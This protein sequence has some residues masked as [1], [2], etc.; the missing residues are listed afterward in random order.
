MRKPDAT[1]FIVDDDSSVRSGTARLVKSIGMRAETFSSAEEFL[2]YGP[3]ETPSCL[4]LDLRMPGLSGMDLQEE[5]RRRDMHVPI[6]FISGYGD[7]P[8][9]VQAMKSGAQDFLTKPFDEEELVSA[10]EQS[11]NRDIERRAE[12]TEQMSVQQRVDSLTPREL[13]VLK[14]VVRGKLNK[15]IAG[16]LGTTEKTVKVHRARAMKK[17]KAGSLADLVL[18][19]ERVG[20]VSRAKGEAPS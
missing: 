18:L 9:S 14:L 2:E 6:I 4:V 15:Q 10:I 16:E 7:V 17:M 1:V 11:I 8:T 19:A 13:Q 5:L 3:P 12:R 20:L